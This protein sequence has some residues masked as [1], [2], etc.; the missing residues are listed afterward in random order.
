VKPVEMVATVDRIVRDDAGRVQF[1]YVLVDWFCV[2][3]EGAARE[4]VYG[5]DASAA[6]WVARGEIYSDAFGL[7]EPTLGVIEKALQLAEMRER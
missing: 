4:P 5:D 6:E 2:L 1:H 3:E 7:G